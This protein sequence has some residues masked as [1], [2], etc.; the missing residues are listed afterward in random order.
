MIGV[1]VQSSE[2]A[3]ARE[4]FELCKT[5]WEFHAPGRRYD[6]VL[7]TGETPAD[8]A[9]ALILIYSARPV[10]FDR[11][12]GVQVRPRPAGTRLQWWTGQLPIAGPVATFSC[13]APPLLLERGSRDTAFYYDVSGDTQV[14][15]VGYDL[16]HEVAVLLGEGQVAAHA[17]VPTLDRHIALLRELVLGAGVS[18]VEIPPVP[19]GFPFMVCL[20]HDVDHPVLTNH[21]FDHTMWG[22][23]HR[24][25]IGSVADVLAHR[26]RPRTL[27]RNFAAA[28]RL[29]LVHVGL[30][31]DPWRDFDR[32]ASLEAGLGATYF[33]IPVRGQPG[34][35]GPG[36]APKR[37]ASPYTLE[38]IHPQLD[39]LRAAGAELAVHGID[40][41]IDA[42]SA[43][44]EHVLFARATN[45]PSSGIRM[46]WLYSG[47]QTASALEQAGFT[48]D[49]SIGYNETVGYRAGT[50]QVYRPNGATRL[51]ELPLHVMDTA[52]FYPS[53]LHLHE[54]AA[55][56]RL[57]PMIDHAL[58]AGGVLT[59]NWHD[60]SIAPERWWDGFYLELL[61]KLK[62]HGA[63]FPTAAE[64]VAWF[65]L[66][67][68]A[69][70][71]SAS[72]P[73]ALPRLNV[74]APAGGALPGLRLRRHVA[75]PDP[76]GTPF[77]TRPN[78][79][80]YDHSSAIT[81]DQE[82]PA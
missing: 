19:A 79:T 52:L 62:E 42:D 24:A 16:L 27:W 82:I 5:P 68:S 9:G 8:S 77:T 64:A 21:R 63:W 35:M 50:T 11:Q 47:P 28:A 80:T 66:R 76:S 7:S 31:R 39:R 65:E 74:A 73:Q 78:Y 34:R 67:R 46:H 81:L 40:A 69:T 10:E 55:H 14:V 22:F 15:R 53:Y 3:I 23:L 72:G 36:A 2:R 37:R 57:A 44:M 20:T 18:F 70:F 6:V 51:L 56:R 26:R 38:Q 60:R 1:L 4:L 33:V 61:R 17:A 13:G 12:A 25:T 43:T 59:V 58:T 75:Q 32:Y 45:H 71:E 30:A 29:P 48:Y 49:S 54:E 41:W